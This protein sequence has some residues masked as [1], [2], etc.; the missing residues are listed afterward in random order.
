MGSTGESDKKRRHVSSLSPTGAAFKKQPFALLS[1]EKKLDAAVLQFQNQNLARK[2]DTQKVEINALEDRLRGLKDKQQPYDNTLSVVKN[3]WQELVDDLE[4]RSKCTLDLVKRGRGFECHLVK[5]D[6]DSPPEHAL[7]SRL[8][9]TGATESSSASSIVN[10]TEEVR[11]IDDEESKTTKNI[12]HNIVASFDGLNNLKHILYTTSLQAVLSNGQSQKVVSSDLLN[13]VKNLRIAVLKLHLEHK[14]LAGDLQSRRDADAK[15]KADLKRLKGD[16]E[17]TVAELEESNCK[18]AIIKA[19][20]DVAK[21][22]IFPVMNRGNKQASSDKTREKQKDLQVM[23]STLKE[24]LDE[25][26]SR[27]NELKRLHE[28]RLITLS[29]L[30]DL[31]KNLKNVTC[32]C[33]SQAYLLLKDQLTKAKVDVVQYQALYEKLQVEKESLYWREKE[34]HMKNEL[35]DVLHRSSAVADSRISELEM[36]IQRYTKEK[37]LIEAKLEE[38]SKEPDRKEIIAEFRALVSSFPERM[39]SM[40]TQLAKHKESAAD[41]HSLRADV[42]SLINILDSKSKD[43]ETLTSR[44]AQQNAEI[45]KLQAMISDLKATEMGLK[46]FLERSIDSREVVEARCA[47]IKAWAHVQGL[48]SSL[49]ERNLVSR[50]KVAIE[51]EAK[52]QQRLAAADAQIAEL[53]HKLEA[54][55]REKTRLSDNLKS[56]HEETEAY[57]SEIE[58]IG[59]AYDDMLAQNQQ[60]LPEITERDDYNLKLVLEGVHARQTGDALRMEKRILEKAVQQTKKTVEFYDFKAGRIEDQLKAYADHMKRVTEDRA[61]KSTALENTQK[62]LFDVKKSSNQLM[63]KLEEAQSQVDGSRAC[64]VELQIDLETERFE[65]KRVEEDLDTLRRK[66]QQ[67]KLQVESSSV[68]EKLRQ[69]LKEYKEILKCSVCLDRRK[70][71]VITKCYHLFCNPCLQ[72]IIETRHRKCPICAASFG[73]NDIKPIYI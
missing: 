59:Q 14:S 47:E 60:L 16:L 6:G 66:A 42:K 41:I 7:L 49:D 23:E 67:L 21:G 38:A 36:E 22:S 20:R 39:G 13:E 64:L 3:S 51:A 46:L 29:H 53:R 9:E 72:R 35:V 28:E 37:D 12:L 30:S 11:N 50:V 54:S 61:H 44:S 43:L 58:T 17:S 63:G 62:K 15:N 52:S 65:R 31:Q 57:L 48:K 71:V 25:S 70:E 73:A 32:I 56:K 19:E 26:T 10:P 2:L 5:D 1:E 18:L 4:S 55:K 40:Q 68:A 69:E 27:L 33:S 8:L 45:Q 24:L 34:F